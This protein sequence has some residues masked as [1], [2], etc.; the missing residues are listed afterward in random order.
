MQPRKKVLKAG[1]SVEHATLEPVAQ[2]FLF[3]RRPC[4]MLEEFMSVWPSLRGSEGSLISLSIA[5][6]PHQLETVLD[7][8]AELSFPVNPELD[9]NATPL[10]VIRFPAYEG[11]LAEVHRKLRGCGVGAVAVDRPSRGA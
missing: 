1:Q 3:Y 5:V 8:L 9:H 6:S 7:T 10:T 4:R 2:G 11:R